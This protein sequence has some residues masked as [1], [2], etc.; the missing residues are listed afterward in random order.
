MTDIIIVGAGV[1]GCVT[2][3]SLAKNPTLKIALFDSRGFPEFIMND[4]YDKR[5][6]AISLSSKKIFESLEVWP[7][8]KQ[9]RIT[10]YHHMHVWSHDGKAKIDF[11]RD[12][13]NEISLGYII[14]EKILR[15]SLYEMIQQKNNIEL[16]APIKLTKLVKSETIQLIAE[17]Q[18]IYHAPCVIAADGA[19]SWVR[20]AAAFEIQTEDYHQTAIVTNIK[21]EL[22]HQFTAWQVFLPEGSLAFLPLHDENTSSIVWSVHS[23]KAKELMLLDEVRF[24][25]ALTIASENKLGKVLSAEKITTF[26]LKMRHTKNYVQPG[27][28]L[29]GDAAHVI[30]PLAGQGVNLGLLDAVCLANVILTAREQR[31]NFAAYHTLRKY[32][33][34]RKADN[35]TMLTSVGLIKKLFMSEKHSLKLL[36]E[37]G[38]NTSD[39]FPFIKKWFAHYALGKSRYIIKQDL[40]EDFSSGSEG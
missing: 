26:P 15:Q 35:L 3:L 21:T 4:E 25:E 7:L 28:A 32:E 40:F 19:D 24:C 12:D 34:A 39:Y 5:V 10:P 31:R 23:E 27:I 9:K 2:A 29:V 38:L 30:H 6:S 18:K 13:V 14:E 16:I 37:I 33:R 22:L 11:D 1:V 20:D 17:D 8:I 36:R